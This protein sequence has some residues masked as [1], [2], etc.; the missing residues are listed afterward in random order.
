M[1]TDTCTLHDAS[2]FDGNQT[3]TV[4]YDPEQFLK[5]GGYVYLHYNEDNAASP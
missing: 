3:L 1:R 2:Y 4:L 5:I